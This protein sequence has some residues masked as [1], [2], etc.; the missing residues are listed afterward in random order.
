[1]V[2][3]RRFGWQRIFLAA[4]HPFYERLNGIL[5]AGGFDSRSARSSMRSG[6]AVRVFVRA[7]TFVCCWWVTSR[8]SRS[9][10]VVRTPEHS[11]WTNCCLSSESTCCL[12][13]SAVSPNKPFA[14]AAA[15]R[16]DPGSDGRRGTRSRL[17]ETS[18]GGIG[19]RGRCRD[20]GD[21]CRQGLPQQRCSRL[22]RRV[23]PSQLHRGAG[24]WSS[25]LEGQEGP[26]GHRV[27]EPNRERIRSLESELP[28]Q[29]FVI[30]DDCQS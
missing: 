9:A 4:R 8:V 27:R 13:S 12:D 19:D 25:S 26:A 10:G 24:P 29:H 20:P 11:E 23:G 6:W 17:E 28:I 3:R 21:R 1:M 5:E 22:H 7:G 16:D 18:A 30:V 15:I 14:S 2:V